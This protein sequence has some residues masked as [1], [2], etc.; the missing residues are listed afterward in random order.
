LPR[1]RDS[2]GKFFVLGKELSVRVHGLA[3]AYG[4]ENV[5]KECKDCAVSS[6]K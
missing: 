3:R 2:A 4:C 6:S 5:C 1:H